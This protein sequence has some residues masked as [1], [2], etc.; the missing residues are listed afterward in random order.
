MN[1]VLIMVAAAFIW[2]LYPA[3]IAV[4]GNSIGAVSFVLLVHVFCGVSAFL[5]ALPKIHNKKET[6]AKFITYAKDM[7]Q[8][9]WMFLM[10]VGL[11]ST[12]YNLCFVLAMDMASRIGAAVI[13]E[14]WPIIAMF[15]APILITKKWD[16][17]RGRD[18]VVGILALIGVSIIMIQGR[19]PKTSRVEELQSFISS[20][21]IGMIGSGIALIGSI[22]LALSIIFRAEV[23]QKISILL[24]HKGKFDLRCSFIGEVICRLAALP[25]SLLLLWIFPEDTFVTWSGAGYALA[26]GVLIFNLGSVAVTLALLRSTNPAINM[27]YYLSPVFAV[28]WLYWLDLTQLNYGVLVG[29]LLVIAA[30][31]LVLKPKNDIRELE[32]NS[33]N[34]E[35]STK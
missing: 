32:S 9:Q 15:L 7:D 13:I 28:V 6:W 16:K 14:S 10:M 23:S 2:S 22:C 21:M 24:A 1:S 35:S 11:V 25:S 18:Y 12:L 8:D 3:L 17:I 19:P 31:L 4:S 27:L 29:G 33:V 30:N 20:D 26:A 5:F 34:T